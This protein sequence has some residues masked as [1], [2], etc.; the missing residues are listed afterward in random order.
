[1]QV[2]SSVPNPATEDCAS[3]I[4]W[5][6]NT[7]RYRRNK[8]TLLIITR[9]PQII[10]ILS[11]H[12]CGYGPCAVHAVCAGIPVDWWRSVHT[13]PVL[14][15]SRA[16][17]LGVVSKRPVSRCPYSSS[18]FGFYF[19]HYFY[20]DYLNFTVENDLLQCHGLHICDF[21]SVGENYSSARCHYAERG[22]GYPWCCCVNIF[23][24]LQVT[25]NRSSDLC[26]Q[27]MTLTVSLSLA[28]FY[29]Y[30][31]NVE[32]EA[33]ISLISFSCP[34]A[35]SGEGINDFF[36]CPTNTME[37]GDCWEKRLVNVLYLL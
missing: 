12:H 3:R 26:R 21:L 30:L 27:A 28:N 24:S 19:C 11:I 16:Q 15:E 37:R 4:A 6:Y 17:P 5:T 29:Y 33:A 31:L 18:I 10:Q 32:R 2:L 23:I 14:I 36:Q 13:P 9:L 7:T 35:K 20:S 22:F 8:R 34:I 1:M 25:V